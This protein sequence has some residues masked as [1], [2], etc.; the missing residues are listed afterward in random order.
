MSSRNN[1]CEGV[2]VF[3][4]HAWKGKDNED[5]IINYYGLIVCLWLPCIFIWSLLVDMYILLYDYFAAS[6]FDDSLYRE[7]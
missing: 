3:W 2:F 6:M 5:F 1:V 7:K 4:G